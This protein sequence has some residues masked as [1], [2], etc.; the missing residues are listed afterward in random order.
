MSLEYLCTGKSGVKIHDGY[1][2]DVTPDGIKAIY[3]Y[4][5]L[6]DVPFVI[7]NGKRLK[8]KKGRFG[9]EICIGITYPNNQK[10][11][12]EIHNVLII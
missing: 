4:K 3:Y 1:I 8:Y 2:A 10:I 12:D 11:K 6:S 7:T 9:E 5:A